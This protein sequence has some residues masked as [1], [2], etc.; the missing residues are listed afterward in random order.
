MFDTNKFL[1]VD[2]ILPKYS[3]S[4]AILKHCLCKPTLESGQIK[5]FSRMSFNEDLSEGSPREI[6]ENIY[7]QD[8]WKS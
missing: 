3:L 6:R 8:A 1:L 7:T 5:P 2:K 4:A